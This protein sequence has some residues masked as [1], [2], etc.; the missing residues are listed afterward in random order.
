MTTDDKIKR[1]LYV[2]NM[3]KK[4]G[5]T[6]PFETIHKNMLKKYKISDIGCKVVLI[7]LQYFKLIIRVSENIYKRTSREIPKSFA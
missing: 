5:D 7:S 6:L 4:T 2:L 1:W 3:F